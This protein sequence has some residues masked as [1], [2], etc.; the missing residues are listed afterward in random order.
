MF[1]VLRVDSR[2]IRCERTAGINEPPAPRNHLLKPRFKFPSASLDD[3]RRAFDMGHA[4]SEILYA[5]DGR[6]DGPS[7][8]PTELR[9]TSNRVLGYIPAYRV[10][11]DEDF[12]RR[13]IEGLDYLLRLHGETPEGDFP[14][15]HRSYR[16][17]RNRNDG[18]FET[19]MAGRAFVEG[20]QL[21]GDT[22]YL[23]ASD[24]IAQWEMACPIS[25][26]N[27]YNMFAVWHLAAHYA[28]ALDEAVLESAIEKT[29]HGGMP[30]QLASGGWPGHNSWM[31]YHGIIARGMAELL[32]VLPPDHPFRFDLTGS[33]T[34]ALNRALREQLSSGEVPPN[35]RFKSRGHTCSFILHALLVA[36]EAFGDAL[37]GCIH[38]IMRY[39]I[40]KTPDKALLSAYEREWRR[41]SE[42]RAAARAAATNEV[43]WRADLRRF[44]RDVEWGEMAVGVSNCWYPCNDF[45][46]ARQQWRVVSSERTGGSAQEIVS[47]GARLFGGMGWEIEKGLLTPGRRYRLTA[48]VKCSGGP[49]DVP[50]VLASAY[51]GKP[52]PNWDPFTDCDFTRENPTHDS[53][54]PVSVAFTASA[55]STYLYVWAMSRDLA[56]GETV[57]ISVDEAVVTDDGLPPPAWDS[58]LDAFEGDRYMILLPT[59]AYLETM[60]G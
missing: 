3:V 22:R 52:R 49:E 47:R 21:T 19:G 40:G 45:D 6:Y 50:L 44:F 41:Y 30:G 34:A 7:E 13:A 8:Y 10:L 56:A 24:R 4:F 12:R 2:V 11:G 18:L 25:P 36:R 32:R 57:A 43:V 28:V 60:F 38:G 59:A 46:P 5:G 17:V 15:Y 54:S 31:W 48:W 33:L 1:A 58:A 29:R 16:G 51:S 14:W 23:D 27:N 53:Y 55:E 37:D 9:H 39:R 35:P 20:Y 42:E 26:N